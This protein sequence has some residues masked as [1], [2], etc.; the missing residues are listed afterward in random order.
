MVKTQKVG[1]QAHFHTVEK[2]LD[3]DEMFVRDAKG[4]PVI[5]NLILK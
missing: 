5:K 3:K 2:Y 1:I 4:D